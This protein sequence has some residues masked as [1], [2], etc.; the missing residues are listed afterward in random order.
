MRFARIFFVYLAFCSVASAQIGQIPSWPPVQPTPAAGGAILAYQ[1]FVTEASG[2]TTITYPTVA[3]GTAAANR[4]V[5]VIFAC[6]SGTANMT[7]SAVTIG[8]I[9]ATQVS[10]AAGS[11]GS[12]QGGSDIWYASVPTGTTGNIVV[13]WSS[14]TTATGIQVYS[15]LTTTPTPASGN[16]IAG[17]TT[18]LN[19]N[20]TVPAS[21]VGISGM[22]AQSGAVVSWTNA[23]ADN[24]GVITGARGLDAAHTTSTGAVSVTG[25]IGAS[26]GVGMSSAAWG[27]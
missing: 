3:I 5:A 16:G 11:S 4:V 12:L 17:V 25:T 21:G 8:G 18:S 10:G 1:S 24:H 19:T 27:P 23:T 6:R 20:I 22:Y 26:S 2:G 13:T 15:I 9:A 14:A 7:A